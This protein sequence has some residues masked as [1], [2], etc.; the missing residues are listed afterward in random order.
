M[1]C[2]AL[3]PQTSVVRAWDV[4]KPVV[5]A[6]AMNTHMWDH[7]FTA[8]H[9]RVLRETLGYSIVDPAC[10]LLACGD[11]GQGGSHIWASDQEAACPND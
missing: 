6:P 3:F 4:K 10:K 1:H 2:V 7:P 11:T 5:V 9:L 8:L